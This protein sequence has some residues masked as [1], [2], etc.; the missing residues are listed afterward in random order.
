M[1]GVARKKLATTLWLAL[2]LACAVRQCG[3]SLGLLPSPAAAHGGQRICGQSPCP[4]HEARLVVER[5]GLRGGGYDPFAKPKEAGGGEGGK[6][7]MSDAE[8]RIQDIELEMSR[9]QKNKV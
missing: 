5:M 2:V 1:R 3:G 8:L 7:G 6:R 4:S 9:T